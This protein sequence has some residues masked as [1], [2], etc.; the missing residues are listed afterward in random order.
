MGGIDEVEVRHRSFGIPLV[1]AV[2]DD[3]SRGEVLPG[4]HDT[5]GGCG[6]DFKTALF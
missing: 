2:L 6:E 1:E 5:E 4:S 3:V